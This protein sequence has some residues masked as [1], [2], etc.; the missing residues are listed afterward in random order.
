MRQRKY[1]YDANLNVTRIEDFDWGTTAPGP[2]IRYT[3]KTYLDSA[4]TSNRICHNVTTEKTYTNSGT[5]ITETDYDYDQ[6]G[7]ALYTCNGSAVSTSL[8]S[9]SGTIPGWVSPTGVR[10]NVTAIK[11]W[12]NT[13]NSWLWSRYSNTTWSGIKW[14]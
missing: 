3:D 7:S 11:Q 12:V 14:R 2:R 8:V 6:Y 10:G 13:T 1:T 5:L 9:R 4:C